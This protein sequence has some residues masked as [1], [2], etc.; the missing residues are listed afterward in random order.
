MER[1]IRIIEVSHW[2]Y[3]DFDELNIRIKPRA[4]AE[5]VDPVD[6]DDHN[7]FLKLTAGTDEVTGAT[8]FEADHWFDEI[9]EAFKQ[10]DV[11]HP[12]VRFFLEQKVRAFAE[13]WV[14]EHQSEPAQAPTEEDRAPARET[15][16]RSRVAY[17]TGIASPK[18]V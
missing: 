18:L 4:G 11:N 12:D 7:F 13:Q 3:E 16:T 15:L 5:Y 10:R 8:I 6:D 2:H 14:A 9:A 1:E 17:R